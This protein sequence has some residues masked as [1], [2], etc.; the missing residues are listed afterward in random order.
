VCS[1]DLASR[2]WS[3]R[4]GPPPPSARRTSRCCAC[5]AA[6]CQRRRRVY[7]ARRTRA[8]TSSTVCTQ[9]WTRCEEARDVATGGSRGRRSVNDGCMTASHRITQAQAPTLRELY[10]VLARSVAVLLCRSPAHEFRNLLPRNECGVRG[11]Q[12]EAAIRGG[13][14]GEWVLEAAAA[15][16]VAYY[17][18]RYHSLVCGWKAPPVPPPPLYMAA[19]ARA[20]PAA[21]GARSS[22]SSPASPGH[23]RFASPRSFLL[24][25][26]R[27]TTPCRPDI[28]QPP[29]AV[30]PTAPYPNLPSLHPTCH[31]RPAIAA[32]RPAPIVPGAL[33]EWSGHRRGRMRA[34][35]S[36]VCVW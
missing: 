5:G 19:L 18:L 21:A 6:S 27:D 20:H 13:M 9:L 14:D 31:S 34:M 8:L 11:A 22:D 12:A 15:L 24:G 26:G 3:G 1:S 10:C 29:C 23:G 28:M 30:R 32:G 25:T 17:R 7:A 35:P 4:S 36:R 33:V 2:C 16:D